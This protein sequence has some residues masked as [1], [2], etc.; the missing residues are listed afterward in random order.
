[1]TAPKS[2]RLQTHCGRTEK[3]WSI[4]N[5]DP[6]RE[7]SDHRDEEHSRSDTNNQFVVKKPE[8]HDVKS[9]MATGIY[10]TCWEGMSLTQIRYLT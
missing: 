10:F 2:T 4:K 6:Q 5:Y 3:N 7:N 1:M 9:E 8:H